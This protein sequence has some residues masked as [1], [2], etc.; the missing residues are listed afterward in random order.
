MNFFIKKDCI[1]LLRAYSL[2][3]FKGIIVVS[4]KKLTGE[5]GMATVTANHDDCVI[6]K[7][8]WEHKASAP[9]LLKRLHNAPSFAK[10]PTE[11]E[12]DASLDKTCKRAYEQV[13]ISSRRHD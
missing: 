10:M 1:V 2:W 3:P 7:M 12:V 13:S 5:M 8:P 6:E 9:S 11:E 4:L